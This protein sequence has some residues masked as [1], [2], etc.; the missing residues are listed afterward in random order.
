M[1]LTGKTLPSKPGS[2]E[3]RWQ[4]SDQPSSAAPEDPRQT[5]DPRVAAQRTATPVKAAARRLRQELAIAHAAWR[6]VP[7]TNTTPPGRWRGPP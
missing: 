4:A 3:N 6:R 7:P 5:R 1:T 2:P